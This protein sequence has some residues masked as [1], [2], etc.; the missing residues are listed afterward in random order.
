MQ[1]A[2]ALKII[3]I[4]MLP[5]CETLID[6]IPLPQVRIEKSAIRRIA[7]FPAWQSHHLA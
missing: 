7:R 6:R 5:M 1:Q 2:T 3:L 4:E